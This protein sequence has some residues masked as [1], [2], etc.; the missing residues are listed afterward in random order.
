M[1]E[2][3]MKKI[4][5]AVLNDCR[6]TADILEEVLGPQGN[7]SGDDAKAKMIEKAKDNTRKLHVFVHTYCSKNN[8]DFKIKEESN[9]TLMPPSIRERLEELGML[10]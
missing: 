7:A 5:E 6:N 10:E 1:S 9:N 4:L 2:K 3:K 8:N